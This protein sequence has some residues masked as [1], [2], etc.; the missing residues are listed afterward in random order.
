MFASL[1]LLAQ[2]SGAAAAS[3]PAPFDPTD[4]S[5]CTL[6][7]VAEDVNVSSDPCTWTS[8]VGSVSFSASG[9]ARPIAGA[10]MN[11]K[12]TLRFSGAQ[13]MTSA[14]VLSDVLTD[15]DD[16]TVFVVLRPKGYTNAATFV[17]YTYGD[18]YF[19][20]AG[21]YFI[22]GGTTSNSGQVFGTNYG[23]GYF[24]ARRT[25][26]V[27]TAAVLGFRGSSA[28][29]KSWA[30]V[31]D[32]VEASAQSSSLTTG[33]TIAATGNALRIGGGTATG[34]YGNFEVARI[35][36]Y[37]RALSD[38]EYDA[39]VA[40]LQTEY[41]LASQAWQPTTPAA[42]AWWHSVET[43]RIWQDTAGTI[44]AVNPG[45]PIARIDAR[46]GTN[47]TQGTGSLQPYLA[48]LGDGLA[49]RSDDVD[50]NL[51]NTA[52]FSAGAKTFA[53]IFETYSQPSSSGNET[54]IRLG[55]TPQQIIVR[56][57]G[58]SASSAKG[59]HVAVDR[60]TTT[61]TCIQGSTGAALLG[62]GIHTLVV[63]YTG[64]GTA[65]AAAYRIWLDGVEV[66]AATGGNVA[67]SGNSRWLATSVP[68]EVANAS[69]RETLVW[70]EAIAP[71]DC[72][73][74]AARLEA[75]RS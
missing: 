14:S 30:A 23:A 8:R 71:E 57:S 5:G 26:A 27:D 34:A 18:V 4:W 3:S 2:L 9:A 60:T 22:L 19:G 6:D 53:C 11:G 40:A 54:L 69:V 10:A 49:A 12:A 35:F 48:A 55:A 50:D 58:L 38:V 47:F 33:S 15:A 63:R 51:G 36:A 52:T 46:A 16:W 73:A 45:D 20:D 44:A 65:T 66:T 72:A 31:T 28:A 64:G 7:L 1:T 62:N 70:S 67:A 42:P 32:Q 37:N 39:I 61:A 68:T 74:M 56:H 43:G 29:A 75:M 25:L 59:W 17:S 41:G 24:Y 13:A 21:E